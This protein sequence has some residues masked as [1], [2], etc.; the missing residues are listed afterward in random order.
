MLTIVIIRYLVSLLHSTILPTVFLLSCSVQCAVTLFVAFLLMCRARDAST[1][2]TGC[3]TSSTRV[4]LGVWHWLGSWC[5]DCAKLSSELWVE[6]RL[7][8]TGGGWIIWW[9]VPELSA[10]IT[11]DWRLPVWAALSEISPASWSSIPANW[12]LLRF[13]LDFS[14]SIRTSVQIRRQL[15]I[16]RFLASCAVVSLKHKW[17]V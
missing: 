11:L 10:L 15:S 2:L 14:F 8:G 5:S 4:L 16:L 9:L 12:S 6:R 3:H 17:I 7:S 1:I 13:V